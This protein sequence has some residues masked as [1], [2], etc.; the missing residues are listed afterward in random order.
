MQEDNKAT[1]FDISATL[2]D[3][4]ECKGIAIP[5]NINIKN[6]FNNEA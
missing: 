5:I 1:E 6:A 3:I 2:A 4:F